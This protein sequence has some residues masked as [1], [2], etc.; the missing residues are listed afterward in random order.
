MRGL[1]ATRRVSGNVKRALRP[2]VRRVG[3]GALQ[4]RDPAL[5]SSLPSVNKE[6][7]EQTLKTQWDCFSSSDSYLGQI[8]R[9]R[10]DDERR[11]KI[12]DVCQERLAEYPKY[13]YPFL[14]WLELSQLCGT[15]VLHVASGIYAD[16]LPLTI[17]R[18]FK[19]YL[20]DQLLDRVDEEIGY[21]SLFRREV[22]D[23][24]S[25]PAEKIGSYY[26]AAS[27]D[28]ILCHNVL[29]HTCNPEAILDNLVKLLKPNSGRLFLHHI[30]QPAHGSHPV[31]IIRKQLEAYFSRNGLS[32]VVQSHYSYPDR[33][34]RR[35]SYLLK[36]GR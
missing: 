34:K 19:Y 25:L 11:V 17:Q 15:R 5:R 29:N 27:F 2:H 31:R 9:I 10:T 12:L 32:V 6:R 20:E 21:K 7:W 28:T 3:H 16:L 14:E 22:A 23:Y 13:A 24:C 26:E 8:K 30:D 1:I 4:I 18:N 35:H 36:R 33:Y